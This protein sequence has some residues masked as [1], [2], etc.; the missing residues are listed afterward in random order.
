MTETVQERSAKATKTRIERARGKPVTPREWNSYP[1]ILRL[2]GR[3]RDFCGRE[4]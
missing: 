1:Y 3:D 4:S 2:R